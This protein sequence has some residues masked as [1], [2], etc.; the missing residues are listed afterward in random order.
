LL[1]KFVKYDPEVSE[2][3]F[4]GIVNFSELAPDA[5][6]LVSNAGVEAPEKMPELLPNPPEMSEAESKATHLITPG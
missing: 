4:D 6:T 3:E 1:E 5:L 2:G